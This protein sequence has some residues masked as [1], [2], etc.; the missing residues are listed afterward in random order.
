MLLH[1]L[2]ATC[3]ALSAFSM[4]FAMGSTPTADTVIQFKNL[5]LISIQV[6]EDTEEEVS[7]EEAESESEDVLDIEGLISLYGNGPVDTTKVPAAS[8]YPSWNHNAVNPYNFKILN[9]KDTAKI[10]LHQYAQPYLNRITSEF[11]YRR[12]RF[13]Y[14]IDIKLYTGDSV[15]CAFDGMVRMV[16]YNRR[17]YGH[18]VVVRHFNGLETIY[19]H[20]SKTLVKINQPIRSGEVL[21]LGGSTGRSTGSHL[22]FETRYLGQAFN[23]REIIDF[24]KGEIKI[25]EQEILLTLNNYPHI[26]EMAQTRYYVIK[27]GDTLGRI[28][29]RNG[30]SISTL[31]KLNKI[32][33]KTILRIGQ[34]LKLSGIN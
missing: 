13:H 10:D 6:A 32:S 8:I 34:R 4:I 21:G 5:D 24:D 3:I 25:P 7:L 29:L 26:K 14:G 30:V 28:A 12:Y 11:G 19:A 2:S 33:T 20:L 15:K 17:G 9:W 22:H 23:P 31:C 27:K 1:R 18:Y 16:K